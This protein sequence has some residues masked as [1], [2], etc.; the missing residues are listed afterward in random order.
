MLQQSM[1][2]SNWKNA[3]RNMASVRIRVSVSKLANSE[4]M[5]LHSTF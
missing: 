2:L 5:I 3:V 4:C 1:S